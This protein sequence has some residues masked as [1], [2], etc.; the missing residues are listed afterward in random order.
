[1]LSARAQT[2]PVVARAVK[3]THSADDKT[4][5][6][7][8]P[9]VQ[10][11][12]LTLNNV[13]TAPP[14][15]SNGF[16]VF[17]LE[18]DQLAAYDLS[19]G[20]RLWLVS[21]ATKV[22]PLIGA[23][24]VFVAEGEEISARALRTGDVAWR[25]PFDAELAAAPTLAGDLL[26]VSTADGDI[27]ALRVS[28]G[29]VAWRQHLPRAASSRPAATTNRLFVPTADNHVFGLNLQDGKI[30]WN[31][32]LG[33]AGHDILAGDDRIFLG[34]QDR[35]FYCLNAK[36]G[37]VEWRWPTGADAIGLPVADERTVYFVSLDNM[38]RGLNRSSGVQ[39]WKSPLPFRPVS[40]PLKW[41]ETIVV[42]GTSPLL[43]AY[44]T[45]DGQSLGRYTVSTELSGP[46]HLFV[47]PAQV[48]PVLATISSDI[49]G[50]ATVTAATR[51]IE[52]AA[53]TLS[54]LPDA[55]VLPKI[56]EEPA[57][58]DEVSPLPNLRPVVPLPAPS[59]V[60]SNVR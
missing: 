31:S 45:R 46:P 35:Y 13:L 1:M 37:N 51:D 57:D 43:Q 29:A 12:T 4:P 30:I 36:T 60:R 26:I 8:F 59:P 3:Q 18:D 33:G 25:Q 9:L 54:P 2:P 56:S 34:S 50:H 49:V 44:S 19:D 27:L 38:L 32:H 5:L 22:E 42:A 40:G 58:L 17:A 15:F 28:D 52:P 47:D 7:L 14:A 24:L 53:M 48:F 39:R 6:S 11:W 21:A 23:A 20:S 16:G 10:T 55:I 41:A